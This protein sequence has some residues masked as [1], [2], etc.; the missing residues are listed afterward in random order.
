MI[1][2][3]MQKRLYPAQRRSMTARRFNGS[4]MQQSPSANVNGRRALLYQILFD[5]YHVVV[6][7]LAAVHHVDFSVFHYG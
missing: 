7:R 1:A 3:T 5:A 4:R 2:P 6:N